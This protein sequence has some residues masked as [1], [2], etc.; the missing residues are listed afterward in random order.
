MYWL[1]RAEYLRTSRNRRVECV[2]KRLLLSVQAF[3]LKK[4]KGTV[5]EELTEE[6]SRDGRVGKED[7]LK[8]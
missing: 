2:S 5:R 4:E 3:G 8:E 6:N 1:D 7:T